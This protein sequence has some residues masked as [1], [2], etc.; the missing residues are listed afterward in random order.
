MPAMASRT[1][2][3][4]DEVH[5]SIREYTVCRMYA[6]K[7]GHRKGQDWWGLNQIRSCWGSKSTNLSASATKMP[8]RHVCVSY[9][10]TEVRHSSFAAS[11]PRR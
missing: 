7:S 4:G 8:A 9:P 10:A 11:L 3:T 2:G 1:S 6:A 5:L